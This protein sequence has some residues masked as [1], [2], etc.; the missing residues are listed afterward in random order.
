MHPLSK[1]GVISYLDRLRRGF[2]QRISLIV[3]LFSSV[4][5]FDLN[6]QCPVIQFE[7]LR[8]TIGFPQFDNTS[9]C[10]DPD[11]LSLLIFTDAPGD[12]LGFDLTVLIWR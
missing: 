6:A 9:Q 7:D 3:I 11:T 1:S 8:G 10:G 2:Y 12:I 4:L 5:A